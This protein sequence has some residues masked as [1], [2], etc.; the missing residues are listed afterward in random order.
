ML[1]RERNN[2]QPIAT[3]H[4]HIIPTAQHNSLEK[5]HHFLVPL[6]NCVVSDKDKHKEQV[7][8]DLSAL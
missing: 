8:P 4:A 5:A 3:S 1:L 6:Q 7:F 2:F